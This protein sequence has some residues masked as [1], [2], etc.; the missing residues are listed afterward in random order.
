MT[1]FA[2]RHLGSR[3]AL[4]RD[5]AKRV[6]ISEFD[7]PEARRLRL[8]LDAAIKRAEIAMMGPVAVL[9]MIGV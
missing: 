4:I 3:I 2:V 6:T 9:A 1:T 7:L 8:E 5:D